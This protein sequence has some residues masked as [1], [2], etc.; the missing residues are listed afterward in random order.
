MYVLNMICTSHSLFTRII[1]KEKFREKS[2]YHLTRIIAKNSV[3]F[4][5]PI[6]ILWQYRNIATCIFDV[7]W[8]N[9]SDKMPSWLYIFQLNFI[10]YFKFVNINLIL[11]VFPGKFLLYVLHFRVISMYMSSKLRDKNILKRRHQEN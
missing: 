4:V 9:Y 3:I 8:T 10:M 11:W 7:N 2:Q 6:A 1:N 5:H